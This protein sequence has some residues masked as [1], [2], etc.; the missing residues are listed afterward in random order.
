MGFSARFLRVPRPEVRQF[1]SHDLKMKELQNSSI[2]LS[3]GLSSVR[4]LINDDS[5]RRFFM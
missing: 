1:S 4:I 2:R 5:N 3:T